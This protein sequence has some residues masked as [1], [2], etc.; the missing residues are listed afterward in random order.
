MHFN[1]MHNNINQSAQH[2][3]KKKKQHCT[4]VLV[5][6]GEMDSEEAMKMNS[7]ENIWREENK[8]IEMMMMKKKKNHEINYS[9]T[10]RAI[11]FNSL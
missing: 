2:C 5:F 7:D 10:A 9:A 3:S 8:N 1:S 6:V 11:K 4:N